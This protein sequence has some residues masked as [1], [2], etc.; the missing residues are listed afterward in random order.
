MNKIQ[1][2]IRYF[3]E[4]WK[5]GDLISILASLK[6]L[7][8]KKSHSNDRI[9]RTSIGRFFCRQHTNDFQFANLIY[10]WSVKEFL[11]RNISEYSVF[12]D[13]GACIGDYSILLTKHNLRCIAFEPMPS[14]FTAMLRNF[15]LNGLERKVTVF[16]Y[17]LG[18]YNGIARFHFNP[19]NTGASGIDRN[20]HPKSIEA[21][22]RTLDS[23][24]EN[25]NISLEDRI[26]IKLDAEGMEPEALRGAKEFIQRYPEM[27]FVIEDKF[28]GREQLTSILDK[29]AVFE[30]GKVDEYN[31]F[32]RKLANL[33]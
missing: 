22:V 33:N 27:T 24:L 6:Y 18:D 8:F 13:G 9:I 10:E 3:H 16:P 19:I 20:N 15:E 21:E 5:N 31:M 30:Y 14:N 25:M 26:L 4:Y 32:A 29:M 11:F 12:I 2:Y 1:I 23:L 17:A 28:S 7:L